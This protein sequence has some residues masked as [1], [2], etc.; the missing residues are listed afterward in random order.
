MRKPL[1][2]EPYAGELHVRFGGRGGVSL[3]YPYQRTLIVAPTSAARWRPV[4]RWR[5]AS[6]GDRWIALA[7]A[8]PTRHRHRSGGPA[9]QTNF[10]PLPTPARCSNSGELEDGGQVL[11]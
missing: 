2:G 1:T 7:P 10:G 11:Y 8:V 5:P 9:R 6:V 4:L 3:P